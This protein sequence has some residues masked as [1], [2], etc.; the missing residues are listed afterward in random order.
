MLIIVLSDGLWRAS[1]LMDLPMN[2]VDQMHDETSRRTKIVLTAFSMYRD[3][4]DKWDV[5]KRPR[6]SWC[7]WWPYLNNTFLIEREYWKLCNFRSYSY[8]TC[9]VFTCTSYK[10]LHWCN[11][12]CKPWVRNTQIKNKNKI[13]LV[14]PQG[15]SAPVILTGQPSKT[16]LENSI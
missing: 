14:F 11:Y 10:R 16:S 13:I 5:Q 7:W 15:M 9:I 3:D 12:W 6:W 8:C 1:K 2:W 4:Q